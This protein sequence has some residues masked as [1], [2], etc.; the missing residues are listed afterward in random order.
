MFALVRTRA[1]LQWD[2]AFPK[3]KLKAGQVLLKVQ[4]AAVNPVDYKVGKALLG[5]V[6]GLDVS[7]IVEEVASDVK[8][9]S[10]GDEVFGRASGSLAEFAAADAKKLARKPTTMSWADAAAFPTAYLTSLQV[11]RDVAKMQRQDKLLVIGASGGCGIAA[12]Q[13]AKALGAGE[14]VA[15]CSG[16][17]KELCILAGADRVVDY[18]TDLASNSLQDIFGPAYFDVIYDC[19][20]NSGGGEN[21]KAMGLAVLKQGRIMV[22]IN[23]FAMD[24]IKS[25]LCGGGRSHKLHLTKADGNPADLAYIASAN[26]KPVLHQGF[27]GLQM[28]EQNVLNGFELLKSRRTRGKIVFTVQAQAQA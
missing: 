19:A 6:V 20:T 10:I 9:L 2:P 15:I 1:G 25:L 24:W 13:L 17:N 8:E 27:D 21:Y 26:L 16:A 5:P 12:L 14:V 11:L 7:G 4:G 23:G 28:T 22:A 3:P 18:K